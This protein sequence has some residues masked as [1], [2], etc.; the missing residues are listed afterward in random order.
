MRSIDDRYLT[1]CAGVLLLAL[2]APVLYLIQFVW[3][4]FRRRPA[5]SKHLNWAMM[6][7]IVSIFILCGFIAGM[8][9]QMPVQVVADRLHI[10][11]L[12]QGALA[13]VRSLLSHLSAQDFL[14]RYK[15]AGLVDALADGP[16]PVAALPWSWSLYATCAFHYPCITWAQLH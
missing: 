4:F 11:E 7:W 13:R 3:S 9:A 2:L 5:E 12:N 15:H 14:Q 16:L 6:V 1:S 10:V 8:I